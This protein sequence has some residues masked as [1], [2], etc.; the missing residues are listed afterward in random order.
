MTSNNQLFSSVE[1]APRDPILGLNEAFNADPN[2]AKVN[3]GIGVYL[4]DEGKI[5]LMQAVEM[6][7]KARLNSTAAHSY[8]PIDG[9]A[10]YNMAVKKLLFQEESEALNDAIV[11][12][13]TLGGTGG[14]KVGA[15]FLKTIMPD[16]VVAISNPTWENHRMIFEFCGFKVVEYAYYDQ[17]KH[18]LNFDNMVESL[19]ALPRNSIILLHACCHN[20]TGIDLSASQW[21]K[22]I[23]ICQAKDFVPFID[24]AYQGFANGLKEDSEVISKFIKSG[25]TFLVANSFSKTFSLYGQRVGALSI[26]TKNSNQAKA[27]LSQIKRIIRTNYSNPPAYGASLISDILSSNELYQI[28]QDELDFMRNRIKLMRQNFTASLKK[29]CP[30]HD[31]SFVN[32]Q[33]GMFSYSGL[34]A[35]Q[36]DKLI[37]EYGIYALSTGR[38]CVAALTSKNIDIV[39][40]AI[41]SVI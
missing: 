15:D 25:L 22:V 40:N 27:V 2:P 13:Q 29:L 37:K 33:N 39:T 41:K 14:I 31:F 32:A 17:N 1:L 21:N 7:Q 6:V 24:M 36:V 4:T 8:L 11:T 18:N 26:V 34:N 23:E 20:P 12:V 10:S 35:N 9:M 30:N 38:I 16:S 3:L 28:W 19:N 5:P